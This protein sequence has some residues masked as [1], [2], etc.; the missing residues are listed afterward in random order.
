MNTRVSNIYIYIYI[1]TGPGVFAEPE[2]LRRTRYTS[3]VH[4]S[5]CQGRIRAI[6]VA[7]SE[8]S[9]CRF[10]DLNMWGCWDDLNYLRSV[11]DSGAG[12]LTL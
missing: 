5:R 3:K 1:E 10:L 9:L 12:T 6:S 11:G 7:F 2:P 8:L 4:V